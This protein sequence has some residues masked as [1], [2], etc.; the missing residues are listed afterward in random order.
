MYI[1]SVSRD[2]EESDLNAAALLKQGLLRDCLPMSSA[3]PPIKRG[4]I[5]RSRETTRDG[6]LFFARRLPA[7]NSKD[8]HPGEPFE[9]NFKIINYS[10]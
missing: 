10:Q 2:R 7:F 1:F 9:E 6:Q 4:N 8:L 3:R 5:V